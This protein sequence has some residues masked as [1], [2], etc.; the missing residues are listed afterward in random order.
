MGYRVF[1]FG[2][3]GH[4]GS[5]ADEF[6]EAAEMARKSVARM[7]DLAEEMEHRYGE[8]YYGMRHDGYGMRE[9][10]PEYDHYGMRH[11]DWDEYGERRRR[12][13]RGRYM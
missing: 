5:E 1:S 9:H 10:Y 3:K 12:D 6:F 7:H 8:R 2:R 13:S 4:E 11:E